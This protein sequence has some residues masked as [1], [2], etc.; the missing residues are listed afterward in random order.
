MEQKYKLGIISPTYNESGNVAT[1]IERVKENVELSQIKTLLLIVD[2]GSPDGTGDIV[3]EEISK[4]QSDFLDVR[5]LQRGSKKGFSSAYIEGIAL[6]QDEVEFIMTMDAD[7]SHQQKYIKDFLE[8]AE[9]ENLD[10]VIGSRYAKGG[11]IENWGPHR[12]LLSRW[13]VFYCNMILWLPLTDFT[14]GYNLIRSSFVKS[15]G[16]D[17]IDARGYFF[18]VE[19]KYKM[20]KAG[21]KYGEVPFVFVDRVVGDSKMTLDKMIE[22]AVGVIKLRFS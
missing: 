11:G 13:A 4:L 22:N 2:D 19:T 16:M 14:G 21:A 7:L 5:L 10:L 1:L 8:K 12:I 20:I 18:L 17:K 9:K 6:I 3:N 15:F